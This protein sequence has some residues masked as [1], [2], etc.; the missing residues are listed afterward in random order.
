MDTTR[1]SIKLKTES[2]N[3][4]QQLAK[5]HDATYQGKPSWRVLIRYIAEDKIKLK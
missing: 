3:A 5:D 2:W 1:Q 4:L